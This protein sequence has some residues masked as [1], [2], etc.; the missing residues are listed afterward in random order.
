[1]KAFDF[2][3]HLIESYERFSRSFSAIRAEDLRTEM[4]HS[5]LKCNTSGGVDRFSGRMMLR[6]GREAATVPVTKQE[7]LPCPRA[8]AT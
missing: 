4:P 1:M 3:H 2:D 8:I 5:T 6:I 7:R